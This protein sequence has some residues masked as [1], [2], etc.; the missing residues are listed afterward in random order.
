[1]VFRCR[2]ITKVVSSIG[3]L[4]LCTTDDRFDVDAEGVVLSSPPY[5]FFSTPKGKSC[6]GVKA[7]L[8]LYTFDL[9]L[10]P[11]SRPITIV[12]NKGN[13]EEKLTLSP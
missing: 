3:T 6:N 1:M 2:S 7:S 9:C 10:Y 12:L 5:Y 8:L 13:R 4:E 11:L